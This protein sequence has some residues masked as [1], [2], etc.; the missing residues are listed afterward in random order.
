MRPGRPKRLPRDR[1][2]GAR[3]VAFHLAVWERAHLFTESRV[4]EKQVELLSRAAEEQQ[5]VVPVYC[6]MPD[7]AHIMMMG[8]SPESDLLAAITKF[9]TLSGVW[10]HGQRLPKWQS[11]FYDHVMRAGEDW[12]N[13]ATYVSMNPVRTG[14]ATAWSDYPFTG[15]IGCDLQ[16]V[17]SGFS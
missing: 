16:D 6:F 17:V 15:A 4:V 9:K 7:H 13:H 14:L 5:C 1:Y 12:R 3:T 11:D 8:L 2:L 10:L